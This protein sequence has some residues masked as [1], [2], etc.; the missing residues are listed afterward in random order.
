[1]A[2][3]A[4][5]ARQEELEFLTVD[6]VRIACTDPAVARK[7]ESPRSGDVLAHR[8]RPEGHPNGLARDLGASLPPV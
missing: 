4:A 7:P 5:S 2:T 8:L 6:A 3:T 1:M